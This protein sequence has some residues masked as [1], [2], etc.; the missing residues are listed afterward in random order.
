MIHQAKA[1]LMRNYILVALAA[2]ALANVVTPSNATTIVR[3]HRDPPV[4]RD[5]R[6]Q[7]IVRDHRTHPEVRDHRH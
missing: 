2:I 4:V 6:D 3:D 1:K 5:H 7:P